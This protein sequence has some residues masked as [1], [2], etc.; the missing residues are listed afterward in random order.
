MCGKLQKKKIFMSE[1]HLGSLSAGASYNTCIQGGDICQAKDQP[2]AR[3][4]IPTRENFKK[5][6]MPYKRYENRFVIFFLIN[7][8]YISP[9]KLKGLLL[10]LSIEVEVTP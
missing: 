10:D 6:K 8:L 5:R 3:H 2:V 7:M 1:K 4:R 9:K